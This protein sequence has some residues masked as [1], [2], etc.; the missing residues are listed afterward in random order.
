ML[1]RLGRRG[2]VETN[3]D[4][5][6]TISPDL[7]SDLRDLDVGSDDEGGA[8]AVP[9]PTPSPPPSQSSQQEPEVPRGHMRT[10]R[11]G[12]ASEAMLHAAIAASTGCGSDDSDDDSDSDDSG[13]WG[14]WTPKKTIHQQGAKAA[15]AKY[16][17]ASVSVPHSRYHRA[18]VDW[19]SGR[20]D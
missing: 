13:T 5:S 6:E 15:S 10:R 11:R 8:K 1:K 20:T 19:V 18:E 17:G 9:V 14:T 16:E 3:P 7:L 4:P 2:S 12:S